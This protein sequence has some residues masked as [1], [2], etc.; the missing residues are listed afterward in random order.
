M[1]KKKYYAVV[2][3]KEPGIYESW[4][5]C[6]EQI[7][8]YSGALFRSF[9]TK[10]EAERF[11]ASHEVAAVE[12]K[13]EV[14]DYDL[15]VRKDLGDNRVVIFTD[16]SYSGK[17]KPVSA[18]GCVILTPEGETHEISNIIYTDRYITSNNIGPEVMAVLESLK[19]VLS[20]QY[21]SVT[22]YHDLNLIGKWA[23]GEYNAKSPIAVLFLREL[24]EK[25]KIALDVEFKW[26]PGHK[27]IKYNERADTLAREAINSKKPVSKYG[28][29]SFL[30]RGVDKKIVD[31]IINEFKN[32]EDI[33]HTLM[34]DNESIERHAFEYNKEKLTVS[35]FKTKGTTLLQGKVEHLFSEFL[36]KYT[37]HVRGFE[38][39][40][41]YSDSFKQRIEYKKIEEI[42]K[43]YSLPEDYPDDIITLLKQ[44]NIMLN[45]NR[46][47]Y[48]Y[49]HYTMPSLRALE[50]H[51]KYLAAKEGIIIPVG[52]S[53]GRY[54]IPDRLSQRRI[55]K[56][57]GD[58]LILRESANANRFEEIYNFMY[59]YRNPLF[60][61]ASID[62]TGEGDTFLIE[63]I[64]DARNIING[65][66]DL[67][68]K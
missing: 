68:I 3:G 59:L 21:E 18:Y 37:M 23:T 29:N 51:F 20:N 47:E 50:G 39:V 49:S 42:I 34:E 14:E 17:G 15:E 60:H 48:D 13:Y 12:E 24:N 33:V 61:Y 16:G 11:I 66:I 22:I 8:G 46:K 67:I 27:G 44:S 53:I 35:Y 55:L 30:G 7:N 65:A 38:M 58:A 25:Y 43:E 64:N 57:V 36:S 40:K 1:S 26:V 54:F 31:Q 41:A 62:E 63:S 10:E 32:H 4:S 28:M 5:E 9:K 2:Y 52:R 19:W 6:Q 56:N 45:L